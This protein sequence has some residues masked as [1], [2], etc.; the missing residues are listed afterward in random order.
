LRLPIP[1]EPSSGDDVSLEPAL[2]KATAEPRPSSVTLDAGALIYNH[3]VVTQT[4]EQEI[5]RVFGA[6]ANATRRDILRRALGGTHSVSALARRYDMSLTAV[7]K[8][9]AM[10]ERAGL[11]SRR[12]H[13][14]EQ[15]VHTDMDAV[16]DARRL[17]EEL[18]ELWRAR[19]DRFGDVLADIDQ[20][21]ST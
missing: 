13:G 18:E 10:L 8:H 15:L 2:R 6:L 3:M 16:H 21:E 7:Q 4:A 19:L 1:E 9:V 20:E 17:L 5:D 12:R 14:R 11:V